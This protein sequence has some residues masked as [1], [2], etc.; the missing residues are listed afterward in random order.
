MNDLLQAM[1]IID[2]HSTSLPE[3]EYIE[4]CKHL[5]NA[6]NKRVDPVYFFDYEDFRIH[7]IGPSEET[8]RYFYDYYF[9]KALNMDSDF[10][11]GQITY[12][13]KELLDAQ[14]IKRLTKKIKH[15]VL[16]H[17]RCIHGF[18]Q[19]DIDLPLTNTEFIRMC[20]SYVD[21][22]NDFRD[23]Y[24]MAIIKRLE[25]LEDSDDRLDTM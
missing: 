5:K 9:D 24:R 10:V 15:N 14:P 2:K 12:L 3:G 18:E 20:R 19:D 1:Q 25:W 13:K 4:L 17:Y 23:K 7:P 16:F 8:F 21:I 11:Q 22:E 6:Y